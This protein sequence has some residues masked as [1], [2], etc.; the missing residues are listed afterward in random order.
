MQ[1]RDRR[2]ELNSEVV[3]VFQLQFIPYYGPCLITSSGEIHVDKI[4]SAEPV[5]GRT[6]AA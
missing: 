2:G 6:A 4:D 1:W 3:F 5:K